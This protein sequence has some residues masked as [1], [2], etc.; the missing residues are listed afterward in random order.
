MR[1]PRL[2]ENS[3]PPSHRQTPSTWAAGCPHLGQY[4]PMS[5][6]SANAQ[7]TRTPA[8]SVTVLLN[9]RGNAAIHG[10]IWR[11]VYGVQK[12]EHRVAL[13]T[14]SSRCEARRSH[15]SM[16]PTAYGVELDAARPSQR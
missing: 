4:H 1:F 12:R 16:M 5:S 2:T 7:F 9:L 15:G 10:G 14:M 6:P 3:S 11:K 8:L 13:V